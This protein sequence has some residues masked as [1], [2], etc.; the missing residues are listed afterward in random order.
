MVCFRCISV[1]ADQQ[2]VC[3]LFDLHIY[4]ADKEDASRCITRLYQ[5]VVEFDKGH[6]VGLLETGCH[7]KPI[8]CGLPLSKWPMLDTMGTWRGAH[9]LGRFQSPKAEHTEEGLSCCVPNLTELY[10][11]C[12]CDTDT[13]TLFNFHHFIWGLNFICDE[14]IYAIRKAPM[15]LQYFHLTF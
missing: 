13:G 12:A 15:P 5:H 14:N 6:I 3:K 9:T 10:D 1:R 8:I 2:C 7:I 4:S 11:V